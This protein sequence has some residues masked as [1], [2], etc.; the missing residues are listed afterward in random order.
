MAW[1]ILDARTIILHS[2]LWCVV[3]ILKIFPHPD[4]LSLLLLET[5]QK[6]NPII[7]S[8][9][10]DGRAILYV[11]QMPTGSPSEPPL[12]L[13]ECNHSWCGMS[14]EFVVESFP[15]SCLPQSCKSSPTAPL[16]PN[17][18]PPKNWN[19][20]NNINPPSK[21]NE[22]KIRENYNNVL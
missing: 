10:L 19:N 9:F 15:S 6:P 13:Q 11:T 7:V 2:M 21:D 20:R 17:S 16:C 3:L 1:A 18:W 22:Y 14:R 5:K 4:I 8:A 12:L